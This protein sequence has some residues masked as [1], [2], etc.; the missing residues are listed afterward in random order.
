VRLGTTAYFSSTQFTVVRPGNMVN[1]CLDDIAGSEFRHGIYIV[2]ALRLL[3]KFTVLLPDYTIL[4][5]VF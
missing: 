4:Q 3:E 2:S 1:H 5:P